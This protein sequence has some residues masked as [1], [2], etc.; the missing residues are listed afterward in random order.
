MELN[1]LL[2]ILQFISND[3]HEIYLK[4]KD[5]PWNSWSFPTDAVFKLPL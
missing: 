3:E 1:R 5:E 2:L 4:M